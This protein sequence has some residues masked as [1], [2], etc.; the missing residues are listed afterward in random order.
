MDELWVFYGP[1]HGSLNSITDG[2]YLI[3]ESKLEI[4]NL[5]DMHDDDQ[6][7]I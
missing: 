7:I 5:I 1:R 2:V 4:G 6:L 3:I